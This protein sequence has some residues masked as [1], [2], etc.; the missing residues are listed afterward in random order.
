VKV[1][2]LGEHA[3]LA[4]ILTRLPRPA[5][6]VLVGPGDDAAVIA[7]GRN[8]RLVVTTDALVEGIH[9]S[10]AWSSPW[11][12]GHK[13][14]AVNL[15]DLAAMGARARWAL[16]SLAIADVWSVSEIDELVD[17]V[18]AVARRF[19]VSVAGGNLTRSPT[20]LTVDVTAGGEVGPRRW[21]TRSG[22]RPG[23]ELWLSGTIGGSAAAL[24]ALSEGSGAADDRLRDCV[25]RH[26][27]PEPRVRLG[28]ALARGRAAR[29]AMDLS[30]GLADAV[31]QVAAASGCGAMIQ[32]ESLP[33]DAAA[34]EWWTARGLD[35]VV[36]AVRGGED[37]ELLAAVPARWT[38]RLRAV[39]RHVADP[40]LTRIG[41]LT[42]DPA[43]AIE[44]GGRREPMPRGFEHFN[45]TV[46]LSGQFTSSLIR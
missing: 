44:R 23:D 4:R 8:T 18:S 14:L 1:G 42:R 46:D 29:A 35:P 5:T 32:A 27:R 45:P 25:A 6:E 2:D 16:L 30:D 12:I 26:R 40:P 22:G 15:S 39:R 33:I 9:F 13:A 20:G 24:A 17:G 41:V 3:L 19:D 28:L 11:D 34:R 31:S 21:L 7:P 38:G 43:V 10:R 37:Y 36:E